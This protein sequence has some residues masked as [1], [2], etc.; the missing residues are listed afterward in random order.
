LETDRGAMIFHAVAIC[1]EWS[2][3]NVEARPHSMFLHI[4]FSSVFVMSNHKN[5]WHSLLVFGSP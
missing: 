2:D 4:K 5:R 3:I 1:I